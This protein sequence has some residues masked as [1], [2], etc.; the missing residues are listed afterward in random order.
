M[1][2]SRSAR[3]LLIWLASL[4]LAA[5]PVLS[6]AAARAELKIAVIDL[7]RAMSDT[8][9][10]L[11]MKS[12]IQELI[13]VRQTEY[14]GKEKAYA[15]AKSELETLAKDPK[16]PEA[17]LRKRYAALERQAVELQAA[18][19]AFRREMQQRENELMV[20]IVNKL[21]QLVRRL[22]GQQAF[23]L[24]VSR[25]AAPFFRSDLDITDRIIQMYNASG[26]A[27]PGPDG[28]DD[29]RPPP[30]DKPAPTGKPAPTDKPAAPKATPSVKP[31]GGAPAAGAPSASP[32]PAPP[33]SAPGAR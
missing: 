17:E 16:A 9:D 33:P 18:G 13:D 5:A 4:A 25:D 29:V 22:A 24:V 26:A 28:G 15:A 12:Q 14:E 19:L 23:D 30:G 2:T 20:P 8:E 1:P 27:G 32:G 21:N 31:A 6:A 11:R 3:R 10:G 7:R